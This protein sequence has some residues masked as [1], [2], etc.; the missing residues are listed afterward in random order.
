MDWLRRAALIGVFASVLLRGAGAPAQT[1]TG[2]AAQNSPQAAV[3]L[4]YE[5]AFLRQG[6]EAA[7]PYMTAERLAD[8]QAMLKKYGEA[9]FRDFQ[10][11]QRQSTPQG[12]AR[13]RQIEK[14]VVTSDNAVL[15]ARTGPNVVDEIRL[16]KTANGWKVAK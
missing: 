1:L 2:V 4:A 5:K 12:D 8:L 9:S 10:T 14:I 3:L 13:R 15:T 11:R 16:T 7:A 6:I